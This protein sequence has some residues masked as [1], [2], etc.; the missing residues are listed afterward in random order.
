MPELPDIAVYV[1][2]LERRI[3]GS[4]LRTI[5][6]FRPFLLRTVDPSI[7]TTVS[8]SGATTCG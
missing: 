4:D 1:E 5:R 3:L 2:S 7:E 6:L 8:P